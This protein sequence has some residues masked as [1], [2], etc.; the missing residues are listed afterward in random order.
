M[1]VSGASVGLPASLASLELA[2]DVENAPAKP[3]GG[4]VELG[5]NWIIERLFVGA[6]IERRL[7]EA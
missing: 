3:E 7:D 1:T 4:G 5:T 6:G 2:P